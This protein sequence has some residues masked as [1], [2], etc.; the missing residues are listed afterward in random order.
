[1]DPHLILGF[2]AMSVAL[3][4]T[5]G[6]DW[7]YAISSGLSG[8]R[9][10]PA[11]GG[12]LSGFM[13][14][15]LLIVAGLAALVIALP[16]L[17]AALTL[18][19]AAYLIWLGVSTTRSW[20]DAGYTSAAEGAQPPPGNGSSFLRGLGTSGT[21]PK[22]LLLYLALIPQFIDLNAGLPAPVQTGIL[23]ISHILVSAVVYTGVALGARRL[24]ASRPAA[25]RIVTLSSGVIMLG[26]GA[27]LLGE[28]VINLTAG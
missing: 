10:A 2:A 1:M 8:R 9:I 15:T 21:N 13:V 25:A 7:A 26:L 17:L 4:L 20:R 12:L 3:A 5:P 14:H 16:Q 22:A 23:G 11:V 27:L 18:V 19:G 24:L 6:A 28:Q